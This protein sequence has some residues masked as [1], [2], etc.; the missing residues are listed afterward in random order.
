MTASPAAP[1][2]ADAR[3]LVR[4]HL[5]DRW[6]EQDG[7]LYI[8]EVGR[9][10]PTHWCLDAGSYEALVLEDPEFVV[11]PA[12]TYLVDKVS[13]AVQEVPLTTENLTSLGE[14]TAYGEL[15]DD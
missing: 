1:E 2:F 6:T 8:A 12:V 11:E 13:G 5:L 15:T 3:R 4:E 9:Q 14:M 10:S 7:R